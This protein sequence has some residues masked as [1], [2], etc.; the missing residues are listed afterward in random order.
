[1]ALDLLSKRL[2]EIERLQSEIEKRVMSGVDSPV[3]VHCSFIEWS[4][5]SVE[6]FSLYKLLMEKK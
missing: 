1:M 4:K 2:I 6:Y 5:L 3:G